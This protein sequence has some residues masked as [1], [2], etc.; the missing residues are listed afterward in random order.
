M[1]R[2]WCAPWNRSLS[3]FGHGNVSFV[4]DG[5]HYER[6]HASKV[7]RGGSEVA[8]RHLREKHTH[9][10]H[11]KKPESSFIWVTLSAHITDSVEFSL[12]A[13]LLGPFAR[14]SI[15][16]IWPLYKQCNS[17][18][19]PPIFTSLQRDLKERSASTIHEWKVTQLLLLIQA[20]LFNLWGKCIVSR[21]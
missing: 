19:N 17:T 6:Q 5:A 16:G 8:L 7:C 18:T 1:N 15:I 2:S 10:L 13:S 21:W 11:R 9:R 20:Y 4:L 14:L 12:R 3:R